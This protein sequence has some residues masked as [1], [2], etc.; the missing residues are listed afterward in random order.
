MKI[1]LE[2]SPEDLKAILDK[3]ERKEIENN[4]RKEVFF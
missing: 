1:S 3:N 4:E 2:I